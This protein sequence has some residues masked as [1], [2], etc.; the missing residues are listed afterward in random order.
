MSFAHGN[1]MVMGK[2]YGYFY[3]HLPQRTTKSPGQTILMICPMA[4]VLCHAMETLE[5]WEEN[6]GS[7]DCLTFCGADGEGLNNLAGLCV[8][9]IAF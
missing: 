4:P 3:E 5:V 9:R 7:M 1:P 6:E 2:M 8:L